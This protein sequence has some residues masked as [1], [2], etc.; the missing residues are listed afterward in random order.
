MAQYKVADI[1][2]PLN[3]QEGFEPGDQAAHRA[4]LA[5]GDRFDAPTIIAITDALS[6]LLMRGGQIQ[7]ATLREWVNSDGLPAPKD[8]P[9]DYR[10]LG[11]TAFYETRDAKLQRAKPIEEVNGIPVADF[12]G[13][14][15][16]A[17]YS[18]VGAEPD[19]ENVEPGQAPEP[20]AEPAALIG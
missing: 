19:P 7:M 16:E 9:G 4:A 8:E 17:G 3:E 20:A 10:T 13:P 2:F 14:P 18:T 15:T 6:Y 11:L 1:I 12:D 5:M